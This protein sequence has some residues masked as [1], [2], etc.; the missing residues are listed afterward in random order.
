MI[1]PDFHHFFPISHF[2]IFIY[3][4]LIFNLILLSFNIPLLLIMHIL[5]Q[6]TIHQFFFL[7]SF[8]ALIFHALIILSLLILH[9]QGKLQMVMLVFKFNF[10]DQKYVN[11]DN[12]VYFY[13]KSSLKRICNISL[14]QINTKVY[15]CQF[16]IHYMPNF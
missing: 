15:F 16:N 2:S 13:I 10:Y 4:Q 12:L 14:Y 11:K 5:D 8:F 3:L 6:E 9:A 7:A 1:I